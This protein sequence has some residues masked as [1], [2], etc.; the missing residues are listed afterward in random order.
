[1]YALES[2]LF[3]IAAFEGFTPSQRAAIILTRRSGYRAENALEPRFLE[4]AS[5]DCT[6]GMPHS[7]LKRRPD[8]LLA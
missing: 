1:M 3:L 8:A 2:Q 6:I 7:F 4:S 5:M